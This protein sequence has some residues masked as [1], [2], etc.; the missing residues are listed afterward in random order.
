[1]GNPGVDPQVRYRGAGLRLC[2]HPGEG[3]RPAGL[4]GTGFRPD[5]LDKLADRLTYCLN[6]DGEFSD[7]DRAR[8][9]GLTIG[10]AGHRGMSRLA[11]WLSPEAAR[12]VEAVLGQAGRPQAW[13]PRDPTPVV[14]GAA[15]RDAVRRDTRSDAQRHQDG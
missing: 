9:R 11:G 7:E 5:Q 1:M 8:R 2:G 15:K 13:Q 3:R 6:P 4:A 12:H 14:D 10:Q